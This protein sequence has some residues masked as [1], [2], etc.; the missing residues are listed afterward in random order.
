MKKATLQIFHFRQDD[1]FCALAQKDPL[2]TSTN[3]QKYY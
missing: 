2:N 1:Q 3:S